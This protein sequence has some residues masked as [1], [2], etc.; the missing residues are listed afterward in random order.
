MADL[1]FL[2]TLGT[3]RT[4]GMVTLT[5]VES[6]LYEWAGELIKDAQDNLNKSASVASGKLA[7]T[8]KILPI[9]FAGSVYTLKI[10]LE[11]YY[12]FINKGVSGTE[13][14]RNSPYSFKSKYPS[15]AMALQILRWLRQGTNKVRDSK[16]QK[17][18]YGKLEKKNKGLS[19]MVNKA[20]SLKSLAYAVSTNIK[21][22]GI[23]ATHFLDNALEKNYPELKK[24]IEKA[25]KDDVTIVIRQLNVE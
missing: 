12:D 4:K 13:N 1:D 22:K 19:G 14:K 5:N 25:L 7:S 16:P 15:K 9:K 24:R 3:S 8:M 23:K 2:D 17:K 18:A 20:D 10:S 11:D 6:V 21:K